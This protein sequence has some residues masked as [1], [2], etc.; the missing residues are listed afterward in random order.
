M[1]RPRDQ[2]RRSDVT[3][4]GMAAA[5]SCALALLSANLSVL[6][7]PAMFGS[8]HGTPPLRPTETM[9]PDNAAEAALSQRI[10]ALETALSSLTRQQADLAATG[11]RLATRISDAGQGQ[12]VLAQRIG[13]L[14]ETVPQLRALI[15]TRPAD[16]PAIVTGAIGTPQRGFSPASGPVGSDEGSASSAPSSSGSPTALAWAGPALTIASAAG[17]AL[18]QMPGSLDTSPA[19]AAAP[20]VTEAPPPNSPA[21]AG[22]GEDSAAIPA[23]AASSPAAASPRPDVIAEGEIPPTPMMR[24]GLASSAGDTAPSPVPATMPTQGSVKA[25]G[26]A[27]G[28]PVQPDGAL[29]AWQVLAAKVGIL[30]VG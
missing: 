25:V 8:L 16:D 20:T 18:Q 15:A 4:W 13:A 21:G 28:A 11:A 14:E 29:A 1:A 12:T 6:L 10:G 24:D 22:A 3:F 7:P 17:Q 23:S 2:F 9:P 26:V 27:I 5:I 30:L 19:S